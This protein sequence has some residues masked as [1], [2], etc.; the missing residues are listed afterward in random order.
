MEPIYSD[1]FIF[2]N[3]VFAVRYL[4]ISCSEEIGNIETEYSLLIFE[5]LI[6]AKFRTPKN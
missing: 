3:F 2:P 4:A 6:L 5:Y 1:L